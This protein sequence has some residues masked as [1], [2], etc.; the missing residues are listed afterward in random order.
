MHGFFGN[1]ARN[2]A[3][4]DVDRSADRL[5]RKEQHGGAAQNLDALGGQRVD[6]DAVVGGGRRGVDRPAAADAHRDGLARTETRP[7]GTESVSECS[8][9]RSTSHEKTKSEKP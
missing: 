5:A 1:A 9:R 4:E 3:I 7:A 6:A 8:T 2:A